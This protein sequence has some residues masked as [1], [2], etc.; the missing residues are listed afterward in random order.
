MSTIDVVRLVDAGHWIDAVAAVMADVGDEPVA[1][2]LHDRLIRRPGLEIVEADQA[3]VVL[4][5]AMTIAARGFG[6]LAAMGAAGELVVVVG[7]ERCGAGEKESERDAAKKDGQS[8]ESLR[9]EAS[10]H[11]S[12]S[13]ALGR[14]RLRR[15]A[16]NRR[17][18]ARHAVVLSLD[19]GGWRERK[20]GRAE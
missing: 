15:T 17:N 8:H 3:H 16:A 11:S 19:A 14:E 1:L 4:R 10:V 2:L 12:V 9:V 5:R 7:E 20:P 18:G 6:I 13:D